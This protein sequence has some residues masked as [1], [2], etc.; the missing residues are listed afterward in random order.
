[1]C[2]SFNDALFW[3]GLFN[4]PTSFEHFTGVL[5]INVDIYIQGVPKNPVFFELL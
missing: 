3:A 1:M 5:K 2:T 4:R